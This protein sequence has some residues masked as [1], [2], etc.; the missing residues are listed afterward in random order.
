MVVH[1]QEA[2]AHSRLFHLLNQRRR[3]RVPQG[4]VYKP[5]ALSH[6]FDERRK[7]L[8]MSCQLVCIFHA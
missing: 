4:Q 5:G 7:S 1:L 2:R 3:I 8:D 6:G